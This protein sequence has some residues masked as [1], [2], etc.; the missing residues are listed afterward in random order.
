MTSKKQSAKKAIRNVQ[1]MVVQPT[2]TQPA[3]IQPVTVQPVPQ[4]V[5]QSMSIDCLCVSPLPTT[6]IVAAR[7]DGP[8]TV[9]QYI[10]NTIYTTAKNTKNTARKIVGKT[11]SIV[12]FAWNWMK[13]KLVAGAKSVKNAGV[14][15]KAY[16]GEKAAMLMV[17]TILAGLFVYAQSIRF[18]HFVKRSV[19]AGYRRT[20]ATAI[21]LCVSTKKKV[22]VL[23]NDA[24]NAYA[25]AKAWMIQTWFQYKPV[26]IQ[27]LKIVGVAAVLYV[28]ANAVLL[29][30]CLIVATL[31]VHAYDQAR[32]NLA[33]QPARKRVTKKQTQSPL[34]FSPV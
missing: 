7:V 13:A 11:A 9:T 20:K 16:V 27:V 26:C 30:S 1:P 4:P 34:L 3:T 8:V 19:I 21:Y 33:T 14:K 2:A 29:S 28:F 15:T 18:R 10:V 17:K 25:S 22:I 23:W 31:G 12:R 24:R 6:E 5:M 32:L